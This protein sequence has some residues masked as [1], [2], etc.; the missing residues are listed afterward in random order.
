MAD[1]RCRPCCY[2]EHPD[3]PHACDDVENCGCGGTHSV[4]SYCGTPMCGDSW[5]VKSRRT[6]DVPLVDGFL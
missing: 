5:T 3:V 4:A 2:A 1:N 6:V